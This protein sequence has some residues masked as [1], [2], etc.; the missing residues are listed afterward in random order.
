MDESTW[1]Q[2]HYYMD[3]Q[4]KTDINPNIHH[5]WYSLI[6]SCYTNQND[7]YNS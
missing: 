5:D 7:K 4:V 6:L 1:N 3:T 2:I